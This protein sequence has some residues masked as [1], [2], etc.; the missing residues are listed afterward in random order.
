MRYAKRQSALSSRSF[1]CFAKAFSLLGERNLVKHSAESLTGVQMN[2]FHKIVVTPRGIMEVCDSLVK[3]FCGVIRKLSL[4]FSESLGAAVEILGAFNLITRDRFLCKLVKSPI[5]SRTVTEIF[6]ARQSGAHGDRAALHVTARLGGLFSYMLGNAENVTHKSVGVLKDGGVHSLQ[7]IS[8]V[9][10]GEKGIVD[11]SVTVRLAGC[12]SL[13]E[14]C[15]YC[16]VYLDIF[17]IHLQ[18]LVSLSF[19]G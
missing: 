14:I 10:H 17:S 3:S 6:I 19:L 8:F 11:M 5:A 7:D 12:R 4:K 15:V 13:L 9:R 1:K 2:C 16:F 18:P